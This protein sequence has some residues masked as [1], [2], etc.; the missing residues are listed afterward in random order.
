[1]ACELEDV[2]DGQLMFRLKSPARREGKEA[3][4]G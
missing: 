3:V 4:D 1:M 2:V